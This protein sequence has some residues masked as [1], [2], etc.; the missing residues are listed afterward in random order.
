MVDA[1]EQEAGVLELFGLGLG[2][3]QRVKT[4]ARDDQDRGAAERQLGVEV[5]R[6]DQHGRDQR[7]EQQVHG[8]D[9]VE[10]V[11]HV[12]QVTAGGVAGAGAR[13]EATVF[14]GISQDTPSTNSLFS[15]SAGKSCL[16]V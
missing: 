8:T 2:L 1:F 15:I 12:V 4:N 9:R 10:A 6:H 13:D 14:Y 3:T 16:T 11:H 5:Q 7:D